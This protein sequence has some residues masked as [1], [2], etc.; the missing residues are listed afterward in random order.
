MKIFFSIWFVGSNY[1]W[2]FV[3]KSTMTNKAMK[4]NPGIISK[5]F[6][7]CRICMSVLLSSQN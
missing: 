6:V 5:T 4:E 3:C 1:V 2:N 7:I